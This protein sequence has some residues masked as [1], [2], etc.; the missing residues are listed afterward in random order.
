MK[1]R[2]GVTGWY[3]DE[4]G[5]RLVELARKAPGAVV[6]LGTAWGKSISY[7]LDATDRDVVCV[8]RW[9]GGGD[10]DYT[11]CYEYFTELLEAEGWTDRVTMKRM[12]TQDAVKDW[13]EPIGLLH[14]DADHEYAGV[15][16]DWTAWSPFIVPGGA[17]VFDDYKVYDGVRRVVDELVVPDPRWYDHRVVYVQWSARLNDEA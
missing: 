13:T 2:E 3:T 16:A 17:V 10:S 12:L 6:E 5:A 7:V 14:I 8:D 1:S 15:L 4:Q 9:D 11:D